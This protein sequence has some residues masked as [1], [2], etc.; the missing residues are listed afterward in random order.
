[1]RAGY[2]TRERASSAWSCSRNSSLPSD[3]TI[4]AITVTY[5][6]ANIDV[7]GFELHWMIVY[8]VL[9]ILFAFILRGPFGVTI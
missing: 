4:E 2:T 8:F 1:M 3:G 9:S 7:F 6:D 5:P